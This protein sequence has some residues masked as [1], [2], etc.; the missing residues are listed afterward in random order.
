MIFALLI[1]F[2]LSIMDTWKNDKTICK[3]TLIVSISLLA[4]S[5]TQKCY[6]TTINGCGDSLMVFIFGI[7]GLAYGGAALTWL[8]NPLL[9]AS[10][11]TLKPSNKW[12]LILSVIAFLISISFLLF[13]K[14]IADEAGNPFV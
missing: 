10:W 5:L 7:L 8:A 13:D 12:S 2:I 6:C 4:L 9:I 14:V 1:S 11:I 3:I